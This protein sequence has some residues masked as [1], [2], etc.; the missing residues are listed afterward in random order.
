MKKIHLLIKKSAPKGFKIKKKAF[1]EGKNEFFL[2]K[3]FSKVHVM[4]RA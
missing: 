2:L 4:F 1:L 3:L